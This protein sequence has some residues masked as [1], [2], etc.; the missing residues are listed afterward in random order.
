MVQAI[1]A[2]VPLV[3]VETAEPQLKRSRSRDCGNGVW[4]KSGL[5]LVI[6]QINK[7]A[8]WWLLIRAS[9]PFQ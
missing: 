4:L 9:G 5:R 1:F 2:S 7:D 6:T 3:R 8:S